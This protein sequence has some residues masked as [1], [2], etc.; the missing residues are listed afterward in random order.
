MA[1]DPLALGFVLEEQNSVV[2]FSVYSISYLT[3]FN[4]PKE[5]TTRNFQL[6]CVFGTFYVLG[7]YISGWE[8]G[9]VQCSRKCI[10]LNYF[11]TLQL[12]VVQV[13]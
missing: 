2:T 10:N 13:L 12:L 1:M 6:P 4:T 7:T 11:E 8:R 3:M 5:P 9:N